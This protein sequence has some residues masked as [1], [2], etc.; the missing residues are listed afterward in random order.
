MT[1]PRLAQGL[2]RGVP[3]APVTPCVAIRR[4][5]WSLA[6]VIALDVEAIG[7]QAEDEG[8]DA[9]AGADRAWWR[10]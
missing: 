10:V 4:R 9:P 6:L 3:G 7:E 8:E 2:C 1:P 5:S